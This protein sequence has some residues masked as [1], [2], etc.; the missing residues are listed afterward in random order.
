MRCNL[1][2]DYGTAKRVERGNCIYC[3]DN[4]QF[5]EEHTLGKWL[6]EKFDPGHPSVVLTL[7]RPEDFGNIET[8]QRIHSQSER[9]RGGLF[10]QTVLNVC[11]GCNNGWMS[12]LHVEAEPVVTEL[13]AGTLRHLTPEEAAILSRWIAML[14]INAQFQGR[15]LM[16]SEQ[17]RKQLMQGLVPVGLFAYVG[18]MIDQANSGE[19]WYLAIAVNVPSNPGEHIEL[20][21]GYFIV[22]QAAFFSFMS[23][24]DET[25]HAALT[26]CHSI[27]RRVPMRLI[28][29]VLLETADSF[30]RSLPIKRLQ[31][32]LQAFPGVNQITLPEQ[33]RS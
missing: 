10:D 33:A 9:R 22:G 19:Q 23:I 8:P 3:G 13:A 32:I 12:A 6:R 7:A 14:T 4:C 27:H 29:P 2:V 18:T 5:T 26:L 20:S 31:A 1:D 21:S 25:I 28:H 24:D 16:A 17:Q 30:G 11:A 15:Q